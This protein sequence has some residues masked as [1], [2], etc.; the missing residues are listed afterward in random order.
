MSE[1]VNYAVLFSGGGGVKGNHSRYYQSLKEN[2]DLLLGRGVSAENI[3]IAFAD[4]VDVENPKKGLSP[5]FDT[6]VQLDR[7]NIF[8][9]A[10]INDFSQEFNIDSNSGFNEKIKNLSSTLLAPENGNLFKNIKNDGYSSSL[11][12]YDFD[13]DQSADVFKQSVDAAVTEVNQI[14]SQSRIRC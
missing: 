2:Y 7:N 4:G 8:T 5:L 12:L 11:V 10:G 13:N 9:E 6:H 14:A 3:I 1:S